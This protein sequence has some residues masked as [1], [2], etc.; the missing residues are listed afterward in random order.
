MSFNN[1]LVRIE[2]YK[3]I[4]LFPPKYFKFRKCWGKIFCSF[5]WAQHQTVHRITWECYGMITDEL[6]ID[7]PYNNFIK[8][9]TLILF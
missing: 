9:I 7:A 5:S 1:C 3:I 2:I 4:Y 8:R 6:L